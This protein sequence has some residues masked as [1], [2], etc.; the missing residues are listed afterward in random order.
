[1]FLCNNGTK[2][3]QTMFVFFWPLKIGLI[4]FW[5]LVTPVIDFLLKIF[6]GNLVLGCTINEWRMVV[7]WRWCPHLWSKHSSVSAFSLCGE[8]KELS[9]T[10]KLLAFKSVFVLIIICD[11]EFWVMTERMLSKVQT[12]EMR[13]LWRVHGATRRDKVRNWNS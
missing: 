11:H 10:A 5:S 2:I 12:S 7:K 9:K 8:N 1:M 13:F 6:P 3:P 4:F